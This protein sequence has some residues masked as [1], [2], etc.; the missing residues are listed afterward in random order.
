MGRVPEPSVTAAP[1]LTRALICRAVKAASRAVLSG[2]SSASASG[3]SYSSSS[4]FEH[5]VGR[6]YDLSA[7]A[8][9][10]PQ[11][12]APCAGV[13]LGVCFVLFVEDR[14]VCQAEAVDGLLDV[15]HQK[16]A[17]SPVGDGG[18]DGVLHAAYVLVFI[19][20]DLGIARGQTLRQRRGRA[21]GTYQQGG[22][23]VLQVTVVRKPPA[24]LIPGV[25]PVK[26]QRQLQ[27]RPHSGSGH[28]HVPQKGSPGSRAT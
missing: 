10:F 14:G 17:L 26:I 2:A 25:G 12:N 13:C 19:Y 3:S 1:E 7:G 20:H 5:G 28:G 23:L 21:V 24:L 6:V 27:K 11:Q 8:E 16:Q 4:G 9:V 18:E 15:P 22:R